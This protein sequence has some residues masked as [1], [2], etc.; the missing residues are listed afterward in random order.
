MSTPPYSSWLTAGGSFEVGRNYPDFSDLYVKKAMIK[1]A[2]E[3]FLVVDSTKIGKV[4]LASWGA[5]PDP[6][7]HHRQGHH[8]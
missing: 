3:V 6:D 1:A 2:K 4:S 7:L 5:G 8:G